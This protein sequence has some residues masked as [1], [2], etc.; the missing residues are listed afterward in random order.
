M[1][2]WPL[3]VRY[4][5]RFFPET[6]NR[7]HELRHDVGFVVIASF[8]GVDTELELQ[9][10]KYGWRMSNAQHYVVDTSR[11]RA[12]QRFFLNCGHYSPQV[13]K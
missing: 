3:I 12:V 8:R 7:A 13:S 9:R 1:N 10:V 5:D 6:V 2:V 4:N 11:G